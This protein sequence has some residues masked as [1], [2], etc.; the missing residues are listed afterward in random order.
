M[1]RFIKKYFGE[2]V[3]FEER[4]FN[5]ATILSSGFSL[6]FILFGLFLTIEPLYYIVFALVSIISFS[7]FFINQKIH[8]WNL[9]TH[10]LLIGVNFILFP[11]LMVHSYK[12]TLEMP[13]YFIIGLV[14]SVLLLKGV[15]RL[16]FFCTQIFIDLFTVYYCFVI[17]YNPNSVL[18]AVERI[19][20]IRIFIAI[21]DV[22]VLCGIIVIYRNRM[23]RA[24]IKAAVEATKKAEE[25][26]V[27]KDTF[28]VNVSHEIRTPLNAILGT[29]ELILDSDSSNSVKEMAYNI[30]NSGQALLSITTDL[31]DFSRMDI[32]DKSK[33]AEEKYDVSN[34]FNDIINQISLKMIDSPLNFYANI[35]PLLPHYLFGDS[36]KLRQIVLNMLTNAFKYTASGHVQLDV[37]FESGK[38]GRIVLKVDVSDTG[39]GMNPEVVDTMFFSYDKFGTVDEQAT[40]GNGLG[41]SISQQFAK[42]MGGCIEAKSQL[43]IGTTLS[44]NVIQ[45]MDDKTAD[46]NAAH[47]FDK[48]Q[49]VCFYCYSISEGE[50]IEN[51]LNY[52]GID[53]FH[54]MATGDF[55]KLCG[56]NCYSYY[57]LDSMTYE[58]L[59]D[60]LNEA[61]T[62]W[63]KV[64]IIC[65]NNYSYSRE[66]FEN[67][68]T[69]PVS[70]LNIADFLNKTR[71]FSVRIQKFEGNFTIPGATILVIDDNLVNLEVANTLL[72]RYCPRVIT[73][74]SGKEGIIAI[75]NEHID[76]IYLDYMMPEMDG[77]DTLRE[78]RKIEDG[79]FVK[80]PVVCLTA[81]AV[82]GARE[83]FLKEG[84]NDYLSKPIE[85]DKLERTLLEHLPSSVIKYN[86]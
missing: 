7:I 30:S 61:G 20:C 3:A 39:M 46:I 77:I 31:L 28:L 16:I 44:L 6:I 14:F 48:K 73:A 1:N 60:S 84:F 22:F 50:N 75:K 52:M 57:M 9:L 41:L 4:L 8:K 83:L 76:M 25:F 23:L 27:A 18:G 63:T 34:M 82:S 29:A 69:R 43:G 66:P 54:A 10:I 17:R 64:V 33:L 80:L 11:Y 70:C 37:D 45:R 79:R 86:I 49:S 62:D 55:V 40:E 72:A 19:D 58:N 85:V 21:L 65:D 56:E 78:I 68:I 59:K 67:A 53:Y 2:S 32:A 36:I 13:V 42:A 38:D 74:T 5:L 24:G 71:N 51:A 26:S 47:V 15:E 35:N 81:N 12:N